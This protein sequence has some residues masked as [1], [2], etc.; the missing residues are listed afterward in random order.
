MTMS[1]HEALNDMD[2]AARAVAVVR[3]GEAGVSVSKWLDALVFEHASSTPRRLR[4]F[5]GEGGASWLNSG[6]MQS[7]RSL[8]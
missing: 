5:L 7:Q 4:Y 8:E 2:P 1:R 6:S 3:A